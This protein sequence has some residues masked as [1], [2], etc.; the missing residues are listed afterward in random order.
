MANTLLTHQMV[1][2]EAAAILNDDANFIRTI[3]R[4][5]SGE[6]GQTVG[7][8]NKGDHVDISIPA[9]PI[10]YAG[11]TFAGGGTPS[12]ENAKVR[13]TV[14]TQKHVA[15]QFGSAERKLSM[16]EFREYVLNPYM[17]G[18]I[19][20]IETDLMAKVAALTPGMLG[21]VGTSPPVTT[22]NDARAQMNKFR[23]PP[24]NRSV[25]F[26]SA[27]NST[28][29]A[30]NRSLFHSSAEIKGEFDQ[31]AVGMYAGFNFYENQNLATIDLGA[32]GTKHTVDT[33]GAFAGGAT[34]TVAAGS[35][36][37]INAGQTITIAG[38]NATDPLTGKDTGDLA[39]FVVTEDAAAGATSLS[40]SPAIDLTT[41]TH[42]GNAKVVTAGATSAVTA[43]GSTASAATGVVQNLAYH[44][45]A[46]AAAFVPLQ[47][48]PGTE[49]S[50]QTIKNVSVRVMSGGD[51]DADKWGTRID[52]LYGVAVPRPY[53]VW[54]VTE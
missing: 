1:A 15:I 3:N 11:A 9:V 17:A 42:I 53:H 20:S 6:F 23:A 44:R 13:L 25:C 10:V 26:S 14:D 16:P 7:G 27:A 24:A 36:N 28:M 43:V 35:G 40:I 45:D 46:I 54:R 18:L 50:V 48:L 34:L 39:E 51:F 52:V 49:G 32:T 30:G 47:L 4:G 22:W 5:R 29:V 37:A 19:A 33:T 12:F 38:L 21:T 41:S 2:R 8:F 31:G